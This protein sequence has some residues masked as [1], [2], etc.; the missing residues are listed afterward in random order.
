MFMGNNTLGFDLVFRTPAKRKN[1]FGFPGGGGSRKDHIVHYVDSE[2]PD[3]KR[4]PLQ[5]EKLM[6]K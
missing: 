6:V 3:G 5:L 2:K 1:L 4:I